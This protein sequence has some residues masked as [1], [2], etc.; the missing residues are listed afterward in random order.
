MFSSASA[1]R[2]T[3]APESR[4]RPA[5]DFPRQQVLR[6]WLLAELS[7]EC[8]SPECWPDLSSR[9]QV[10]R[11]SSQAPYLLAEIIVDS[12]V[13]GAAYGRLRQIKRDWAFGIARRTWKPALAITAAFVLLGWAGDTL[14]PGA[15]SIGDFFR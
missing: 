7:L 2:A 13:A 15:D 14:Q 4:R 9:S 1:V 10:R 11:R 3:S 12:L 6:A 8:W 5:P